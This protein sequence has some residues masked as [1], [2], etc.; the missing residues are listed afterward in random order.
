MNVVEC[1]HL[2]KKWKGFSLDDVSFTIPK[3]YITG[4]IGPNGSGK[5]TTIKLM[6]ELFKLDEGDITLFGLPHTNSAVKQRIGFVYDDLFMYEDFTIKK[7]KN[8]IAPIYEHW[9]EALF[10]ELLER[11]ELPFKKKLKTFSKGMKMK[12]SLLFALAHEPEFIIMDEPTAGLDPI[13]RK[14]LLHILQEIMVE[15]ERTI[16]LSTHITTDLDKIADYVVLMNNGQVVLQQSMEAIKEEYHLIKGKSALLDADIRSMFVHIEESNS[17]FQA[18]FKGNPKM[19]APFADELI[20][21][22]ATLDDLM[23]FLV[24]GENSH[25]A[26]RET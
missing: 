4:F 3:G 11:F 26:T 8:F 25:V 23:Y 10:N 13:F 24:K 21:E 6:M 9:N 14:E 2:T 18:L 17:G 12:C 19:F 1:N 15:A 16:F 5:T 20:I 22:A 7:M